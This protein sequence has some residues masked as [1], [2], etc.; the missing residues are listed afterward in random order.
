MFHVLFQT[1]NPIPNFI[2]INPFT[3]NGRIVGGKPT[4][5]EEVPHQVQLQAY[6]FTFCGGSILS[7]NYVLTAGHCSSYSSQWVTVRAGTTQLSSGGSV[8]KVEKVIRHEEYK[9]NLYGIPI[10]D[11]AVLKL[12]KPFELDASRQPIALFEEDEEAVEGSLSTITGW[13][14]VKEGG[15]TSDVLRVVDVPIVSKS[16]CYSAYSSYGGIPDGQICAAH[17]EGGKDACQ[18]DSGGPLTIGGK[19]AGIVSWENGCARKGY[20]GV[21]TEVAAFKKWIIENAELSG[22]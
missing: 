12:E 15:S 21:Y 14:T 16:V 5:I 22:V 9:T 18:G 2:G 11:V 17:P 1:A 10:N 20:P 6:G 4:T 7:E 3:P 19:L 13:G 8:H